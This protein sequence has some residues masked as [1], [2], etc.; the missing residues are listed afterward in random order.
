MTFSD[1]PA[2][3]S[4]DTRPRPARPWPT[5]MSM[6]LRLWPWAAATIAAVVVDLTI[7]AIRH[8]DF[9]GIEGFSTMNYGWLTFGLVGGSGFASR[10]AKRPAG[11]RVLPRVLVAPLAAFTVVFL[12]VTV[13]AV[14]FLPGQSLGETLT[15]DAPGRAFW[16]SLLVGI[17]AAA[18]ELWWLAVRAWRRLR[19]GR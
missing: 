12:T 19:T 13:M 18:V 2:S 10:L 15:T 4:V 1:D 5:T 16:L 7:G 14:W 8:L 11:W 6:W 17:V 3:R 9:G